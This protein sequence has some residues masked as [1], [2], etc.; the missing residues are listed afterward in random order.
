MAVID[1]LVAAE[2]LIETAVAMAD[3][4]DDPLGTHVVASSA[5]S[6]LRELVTSQGDDYVA[7]LLKEASFRGAQAKLQGT[8]TGL[9]QSDV[10]DEI[11]N[12]IARGIEAGAVKTTEDI[13]I[14]TPKQEVRSY[15]DYIFKP[16]NFLKHA[17]R[18]PLATLDEGDF[19]PEGALTHAMTAYLMARGDGKLPETFADFLKKRGVL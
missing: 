8:P 15:L 19:D 6:L 4:Q 9:P 1:K 10:I 7:R 17:D 2:R 5:L 14:V 3:R 13:I 16:Y 18:D 12:K 11:V